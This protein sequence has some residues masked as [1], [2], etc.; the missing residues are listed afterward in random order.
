MRRWL[1]VLLGSILFLVV[2]LGTLPWWLEALRPILRS[3]RVT[4]ERYERIGYG[5][6]KL[7]HAQ[8]TH[9]SVTITAEEVQT[10]SPLLWLA[11]YLRDDDP[12]ITVNHW[13]LRYTPTPSVPNEKRS[14]NGM[15]DLQRLLIRLV[16]ILHRWLPKVQLNDGELRGF[17]PEMTIAHGV[18][19]DSALKVDGLGLAGLNLTVVIAGKPD[20][21]FDVTARTST[22]EAHVELV[23]SAPDAKGQGMWWEQSVQLTGHFA[24]AGWLPAEASA[25][26]DHW[27]LAAARLKL[28]APYERVHGQARLNWHNN[29]YEVSFNAKAEPAAKSTAPVFEAQAIA[30]GNFHELTVSTLHVNAPFATASLSAPITFS[31]THPWSTSAAELS[32]NVD[33]AKLPWTEA[34]GNAEG[35]V[36][37]TPG[38][39]GTRQTFQLDFNHVSLQNYALEK[40]RVRGVLEWPKLTLETLEAQ[41]DK[42]SSVSAHGAVDWQTRELH[43]S[44][45]RRKSDLLGLPTGCQTA[46]AG[47]RPKSRRPRRVRSM[48]PNT[49][50][51]SN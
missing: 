39:A 29:A 27:D 5:S 40:A 44:H 13:A 25:V 18:W 48:R 2:A 28:G 30:H 24:E 43:G 9:P 23:W 6:F 15:A 14:L 41:L 33:L 36:T 45:C 20:K 10:D 21:T 35:H 46:R 8:Y 19:H 26:A 16:P 1:K 32:V 34:H 50:A 38:G 12:L 37:I 42:T 3:Q 47:P 22:K 31:A 4:F 11:L 51:P 49:T 7:H 17:T